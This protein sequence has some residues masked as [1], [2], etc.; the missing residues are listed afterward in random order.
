MKNV[1]IYEVTN[2]KDLRNFIRFPDQLYNKSHYYIPA[3]HKNEIKTLSYKSNPAFDYC[4]AKYWLAKVNG[5]IVG[6]VAGILNSKYNNQHQIRFARFGW[7]DF[8]ED[9]EVLSALLNTVETWAKQHN[10]EYI[11]GPLG[12]VSFDPSGILVEGFNEFPTSTG[13]YN[14]PYYAKLIERC[15][16]TKEREW[17]EY[18]LTV[19]NEIPEN[20][21]RSAQLIKQ[22]YNLHEAEINSK[23]DILKYSDAVFNLVNIA[24]NGLFI[25]SEISPEEASILSKHYLGFLKPE[26]VSFILDEHDELIAF[27]IVTPSIAKALQKCNG[28]L[29]PVGFL[30]ILK[31]L[32]KNDTADLLLI[33]VKPTYQNRGVHAIIFNKITRTLIKNNI[34][35]VE[36]NREEENN[37]KV[38]NLWNHYEHRQHKRARCYLKKL[39]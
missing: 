9:E 28:R 13:H 37:I 33:A 38:K 18:I 4:I 2:S 35:K 29:F 39:V 34:K 1:E 7:L 23:K 22:R 20:V 25:F 36:S 21:I 26:Y 31:A 5:K 10:M 17:V 30:H 3:I 24:Y 14:Y 11:H 19:P 27:G 16:Y 15:G 12:F 6:R 8:I 32:R